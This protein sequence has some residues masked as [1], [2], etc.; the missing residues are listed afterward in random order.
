MI[1]DI[2]A[3]HRKASHRHWEAFFCFTTK[4]GIIKALKLSNG[5][6]A[7]TLVSHDQWLLKLSE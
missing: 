1:E 4:K 7:L 6:N 5:D 2:G 3:T